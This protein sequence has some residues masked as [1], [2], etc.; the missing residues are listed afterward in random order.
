MIA[1]LLVLL[2]PGDFRPTLLKDAASVVVNSYEIC[3]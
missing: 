1:E 2:K 3:F